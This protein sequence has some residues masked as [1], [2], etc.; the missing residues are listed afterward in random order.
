MDER[1]PRAARPALAAWVGEMLAIL[2]G[3]ASSVLLLGGLA[4]GDFAP[5]WSDLDVCVVARRLPDDRALARLDEVH[6]RL[7]GRFVEGGEGGWASSQFVEG[8]VLLADLLR[9]ARG[10]GRGV[11]IHDGRVRAYEAATLE[12]FDR[13]VLHGHGIPLVG[14][15]PEVAPPS[16]ADLAG[17]LRRDL[18]RFELAGRPSP[19]R[20]AALLHWAARSLVFWRDGELVGKSEA[21]AREIRRGDAPAEAFALALACREEGT[22]S[23]QAAAE[24]LRRLFDAARPVLLDT[25][26]RYA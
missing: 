11:A 10:R 19:V 4:L 26:A 12:P 24:P 15:A 3:D 7:V 2:G 5:R 16:E 1:I 6:R 22:A 25:L 20:R 23:A 13:L 14:N 9:G 18:D 8:V 17:Q 21:L